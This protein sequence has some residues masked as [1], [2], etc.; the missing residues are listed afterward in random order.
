MVR[1]M[2]IDYLLHKIKQIPHDTNYN[3]RKEYIRT[4]AIEWQQEFAEVNYYY[5]ELAEF[6][7]SF[8]KYGKRYGLLNEFRENGIL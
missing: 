2:D 1:F 4:I 8:K 5:S 3:E 6:Y 7:K